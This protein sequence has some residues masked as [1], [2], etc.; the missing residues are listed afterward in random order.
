MTMDVFTR[1]KDSYQRDI[2]PIGQYVEQMGFYL[3]SMT[4]DSF[5][6]CKS[7]VINGIKSG[8]FPGIC[9]PSVTHFEREE[10]G[11]RHLKYTALTDYIGSIVK[12]NEVLAP[13]GT[14]YIN[15]DVKQSLITKFVDGN[16]KKRSIAKKESFKAKA[17][18]DTV[19]YI[20]KNNEQTYLKLGNNSMSGAFVAKGSFVNNPSAHS[21]LTSTTRTGTSFANACNEKLIAGNRHYWSPDIVLNNLISVSHKSNYDEIS[22][23][24]EK[25]Q[26]VYPTVE[27]VMECITY[28][29]DLY[30]KDFRALVKIKDFVERM[31]PLQR[32]AFVYTGDLYHIRK[33]N[34]VFMRDFISKMSMK[35]SGP[36]EDALAKVKGVEEFVLIHAHHICSAEVKGHGKDY[37]KMAGLGVLDTLVAT[38][39]HVTEVV[40]KYKDFTQAFFATPN[41]PASV[42]YI[43]DMIRRVVVISDTDSTC[44][45]VDEWVNWN[46]GAIIFD[47]ESLAVSSVIAYYATQTFI[48]T[49]ALYSANINVAREKLYTLAYKSEWTWTIVLPMNVAKHYVARAIVQEGNVFD[50]A[51]LEQKGV[52]LKSSNA[53]KSII[54]DSTELT[55]RIL[56]TITSNKKVSMAE[57]LKY[58]ADKERAISESLLCGDLE[59]YRLNKI[60]EAEAY[61]KPPNESPFQHHLLWKK[62]F[63]PKYGDIEEPAYAT[64]KVPTILENP[65]K[66]KEWLEKI[67]DRDLAARMGLWL[68]EANKKSFNT[69]YVSSNFMKAFGMPE[70][71]RMIV[72][73]KRIILDLMVPFY[74]LI[75]SLGFYKK[76]GMMLMEIGY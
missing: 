28:S 74:M 62:V 9:N 1:P 20:F 54:K 30:W 10:N 13:S 8:Q 61:G 72:D 6:K 52:H 65:T 21:T 4:G 14:T 45:S 32:A 3:S 2:D 18:K 15:S 60:K 71:I 47:D 40:Y 49:M 27:N 26:L 19:R 66:I 24:I 33:F 39:L 70:E 36:V 69:F 46:R 53:P 76:D 41:V 67:P 68:M 11:D 43:R 51:E 58:V 34:D 29:S 38:A 37:E 64:A 73:T 16:T 17:A 56:D 57:V 44:F 7:F 25:Y 35:I 5:E 23:V 48:H 42:G 50:E 12:Q 22:V 31:T 75:E 59:F 63:V 55:E